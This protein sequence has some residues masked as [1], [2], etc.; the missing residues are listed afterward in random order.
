MKDKVA[1][2]IAIPVILTIFIVDTTLRIFGK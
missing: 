2:V 1:H